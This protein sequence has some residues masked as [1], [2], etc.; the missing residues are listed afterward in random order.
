MG[1]RATYT[2]LILNL[3]AFAAELQ[4]GDALLERYALWP[5]GAG[6]A[7]WQLL[8]SAFLHANIAHLA[9]NLFGLWMFGREVERVLGTTRF[10]QLYVAS[11]ISAALTQLAVVSSL[12]E[13]IPTVGASGAV[14]GVLMAF[15]MLF[16]R[17][18]I[19]LLFPP[20]PLPARVFVLLYAAFEL[21]AGVNGTMAGVA[22]FA[23]LG[24]LAGAWLLMRHWRS[25]A[26]R[27][28]RG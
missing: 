22:H 17:R 28:R 2:L 25:A 16:P 10:V 20:I 6:F 26:L 14:F 27:S 15:A 5:L 1:A 11:L 13:P 23:H 7:L 4:L 24:G 12:A 9:T 3:L 21:F 8:S 18:V 19:I